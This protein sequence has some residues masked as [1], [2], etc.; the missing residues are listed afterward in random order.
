MSATIVIIA[1]RQRTVYAQQLAHTINADQILWDN[2]T[3][4][5]EAN[6][7]AAHQWH[8]QHRT[9]WAVCIE[10]DAIPVDNF[11]SQ[12]HQALDM[13]PTPIVS[14]YLGTTAPPQHQP[15]ISN[16][17]NL[18]DQT[19]ASWI[20]GTKLLHGV[21]YAIRHEL[22]TSL[23]R[24]HSNL[25]LD[26]HISWWCRRKQHQ[27]ASTHPS[28]LDHRDGP[29][30]ITQRHDGLQR[31]QPRKAWKTGTRAKW[32]TKSVKLPQH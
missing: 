3:L 30:L 12:L 10:D 20:I 1:H 15:I 25:P 18:A 13:A 27:V 7:Q 23:L 17:I 28:L 29:P 14:L 4:G 24:H 26:Q 11:T 16:A 2:G 21:G 6:H 31:D 5:C 9:D 32:T 22:L 19:D 8:L